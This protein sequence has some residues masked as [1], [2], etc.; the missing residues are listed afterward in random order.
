MASRTNRIALTALQ[1]A[2]T[3]GALVW[4]LHDPQKRAEMW[5]ILVQADPFWF[6]AGI[7]TYG[8]VEIIAAWRWEGLLHVQGI[9]LSR[10]RLITLLLIG[11]FFNFFI[12]GGTG[13]DVV[14]IYYLIKEAPGKGAGAV[15]SVLVD[16]I[17][18][19]F[20]LILMAAVF[21]AMHWHWLIQTTETASCVWTA[22]IILAASI[23]AVSFSYIVTSFGLVH[24]LPA[25]FPMRDRLAE[26]AMAYNLYG[27]AWRAS[28]K[29]VLASFASHFGY[30]FT[31]YCAARAFA[32]PGITIPT[33]GQL[34]IVMPLIN[35]ITALPISIGGIG[36]RE[37]LFQ[38]LLNRL[39]GVDESVAFLISSTGFA[40]TAVWGV[41][42]GLLYLIYRPTEHVRLDQISE[43]VAELEHHVAEDEIAEEEAHHP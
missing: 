35:T 39:T 13:G 6:L 11:V 33:Y 4:L 24:R 7:A 32:A 25:K 26:L 42:G 40:A 43:E 9:F 3:I 21:I 36:V 20:A 28:S 29:A 41:V 14:K 17:V 30:F 22:L 1:V 31:F 27:R 10:T 18:G 37:K 19:L 23:V 8:V 15:L 5:R 34:C 2:I 38:V 16:R 12:P